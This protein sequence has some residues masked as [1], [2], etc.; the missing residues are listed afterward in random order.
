MCMSKVKKLLK[1]LEN[2][3][4]ERD[5]H[6][7]TKISGLIK[8][9][10]QEEKEV[11]CFRIILDIIHWM[12]SLDWENIDK[13]HVRKREVWGISSYTEKKNPSQECLATFGLKFNIKK[14]WNIFGKLSG[15]L[16]QTT[17][18][19]TVPPLPQETINH[20]TCL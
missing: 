15:D 13:R 11:V 3:I 7:K 6:S 9:M 16:V 10:S 20:R 8:D 12:E 14:H 19:K 17:E 18:N 2:L 5:D 4:E 1:E